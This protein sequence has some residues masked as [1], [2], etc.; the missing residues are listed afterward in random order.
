[1]DERMVS[2]ITDKLGDL[3][4]Q[5]QLRV[6]GYLSPELLF[7]TESNQLKAQTF[8][9]VPIDEIRDYLKGYLALKAQQIREACLVI[10]CYT[11]PGQET[12]LS[13]V[14]VIIHCSKDAAYKVGIIEYD[15]NSN[16][17]IQKPINWQNIYW[18]KSMLPLARELLACLEGGIPT[19]QFQVSWT[20][21]PLV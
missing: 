21:P 9:G 3:A 15:S 2:H 20:V 16:P 13:D 14:V 17:V 10:D 1:M 11:E 5:G 4:K 7:I 18:Q 8:A 6:R 19:R 12:T